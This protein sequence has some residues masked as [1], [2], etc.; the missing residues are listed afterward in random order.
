MGDKIVEKKKDVASRINDIAQDFIQFVECEFGDFNSFFCEKINDN[1]LNLLNFD[2][3]KVMVYG[4]YNSGKS[5]LIN[6]L[7]KQEVAEV[8]DRPMTDMI[9]EYDRGDFY[10]VDSPGV[11]APIQHEMVTEEYIN[12]CHIIL[13]VISSKGLF[14]DRTNYKKLAGLIAKEIP[15]VIVLNDRGCSLGKDWDD[16]KKKRAKFNHEQELNIIQY[17]IIQNL[18]KESNDKKIAEK[19]EVVIL[20]AKKAW[21]GVVKEKPQLYEASGVEFLDKRIS[22]LLNNDA[23]INA[24]FKQPISN[25]KE[26]LNEIEKIITQTMSGNSTD[27][28][29]MRIHILESKRDNIMQDM[30]VLTQQA[31]QSR[32][33]ELTNSYVNGDTDIFETISNGIFLDVDDRYSAKLNELFVCV[34]HNFKDLNLFFDTTSNL[35]FNASGKVGSRLPNEK[36][37]NEP[38]MEE[39]VVPIEKRGFFD[40][41]KS[42]K[43]REREKRERLEREAR[44]KN[45][46]MQYKVQ[47]NIRKRQESRQLAGSDLDVLYRELIAIVN[48]GMDEKYDEIISHIQQIDC[49]NRQIREDGKRQM[50]KLRQFRKD[51]SVIENSLN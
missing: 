38:Y 25:F 51:I 19:Y 16:E 11:D 31:V 28:F 5:T 14:E 29:G 24:V 23:S 20:N 40:F 37:S 2:K 13:F 45:E 32:L 46:R 15:F 4:I 27:D 36:D 17:K 26:C 39:I 47:E 7:C 10:L 18:I 50:D 33:D 48:R 22:Q 9:M 43:K 1:V 3:P 8:A 6:S 12:K 35:I 42:R 34:D 44:L 41:L 21:M 30:R 49:S